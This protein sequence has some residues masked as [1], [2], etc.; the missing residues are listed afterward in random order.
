MTIWTHVVERD[1]FI[2][3][4]CSGCFQPAQARKR[5][6]GLGDGCPH[7]IRADTMKSPSPA[8]TKRRNASFGDT[9]RCADQMLRP[10][11]TQRRTAAADTGSMFD[12]IEEQDYTYVPLPEEYNWPERPASKSKEGDHQ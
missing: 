6:T 8:W 4:N 1:A 10:P 2:E 5:L 3:K 7:L 12:D 11:S 9:Y